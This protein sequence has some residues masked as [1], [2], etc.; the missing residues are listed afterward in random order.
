MID[1]PSL[2]PLVLMV[3]ML[4]GCATTSE[5]DLSLLYGVTRNAIDQ[6]PVILVH[7]VLGA[8]LRD[9]DSREELWPGS[10]G[11]LLFSDFEELALNFDPQTLL[12][13][14]DELEAFAI[15][16]K[17]AGTD[18]YG[19][20]IDTLDRAGGYVRADPGQPPPDGQR[21][22]Y[23]FFYDWRQDNVTSARKLDHFIEQIRADHGQPDL[24][25]DIVAHSMGGLITRYYLRYGTQDVLDDNEF[26]VNLWGR[27]RVRRVILLGTPNLGSVDSVSAFI[28]GVRVGL[29]RIPTEVLATMPSL[30]QLFPHPINKDWIIKLDGSTLDRDLFDAELWRRFQWSV[31]DPVVRQRVIDQ[32]DNPADGQAYLDRLTDYF[33]KHIE[34]GRRFVWSL[35]VALDETPWQLILFGGDCEMTPARLLV[36]EVAGES[37]I[38]LD[39][40]QI[41]QPQSGINYP[42]LMLEPGDG[43]VTKASLLARNS[44]D[45]S[46]PRHPYVFFPLDYSFF[47]CESHDQLTG[48]LT[49]RDNLLHVLLSR[50]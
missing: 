31:Y 44:L 43:T 46:V 10:L 13:V 18:F 17:A 5:P 40:D 25:V 32:F 38:R 39:P 36:E 16:D 19:R 1:R 33:E 3:A 20:I 29:G 45:P 8:R 14:D 26:P 47:I 41:S 23:V 12:P 15:T 2:L 21:A 9:R 4:G 28:E 11:R 42:R 27:S 37:I 7:G 34:R 49:F 30:Y 6:P 50:Q 35:T 24:K 48:N 22:Y